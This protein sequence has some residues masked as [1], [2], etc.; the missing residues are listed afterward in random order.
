M[1]YRNYSYSLIVFTVEDKEHL[2][3]LKKYEIMEIQNDFLSFFCIEI[4][5]ILW[6]FM[7]N[8]KEI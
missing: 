1:R 6:I 2:W 7:E 5:I 4:W 3:Q 8:I